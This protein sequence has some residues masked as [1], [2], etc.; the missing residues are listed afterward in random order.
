VNAPSVTGLRTKAAL[1]RSRL[2]SRRVPVIDLTKKYRTASGK[3]VILH[4]IKEKN[5]AG[6]VV[7]FPVKGSIVIKEKPFKTRYD[8]WRMDGRHLAVGSSLFD[9]VEVTDVER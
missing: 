3:R 7:T 9:L 4:E 8:I 5:S 1:S 6:E 2:K